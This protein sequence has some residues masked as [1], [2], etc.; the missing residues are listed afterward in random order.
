MWV[1][2]KAKLY[3]ND[4]QGKLIFERRSIILDFLQKPT[5]RY[6]YQSG[7]MQIMRLKKA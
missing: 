6:N 7:I 5:P 1:L 2:L 4:E 3:G